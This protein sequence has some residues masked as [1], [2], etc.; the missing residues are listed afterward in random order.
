MEDPRYAP[1]SH[2][3]SCPAAT[4]EPV[5]GIQCG[6]YPDGAHRCRKERGSIDPH[7][8]HQCLCGHEW[9]SLTADALD[10]TEIV[11]TLGRAARH[12]A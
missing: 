7:H 1:G 5:G 10:D 3:E 2:F 12:A 11:A 9:I 6:C 4:G 8:R